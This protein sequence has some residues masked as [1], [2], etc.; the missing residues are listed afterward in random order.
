MFF[1]FFLAYLFGWIGFLPLVLT[2]VG[3]GVIRVNVPIE[4]IVVGAFT[5][6]I[7]ALCTQWMLDR[8]FRIC[9]IYSSWKRLLLGSVIGLALIM[10]AFTV[11]PGIVLVRI[12]PRALHWSALS[13][14]TVYGV[15]WSTFLGGPVNEE[16]GWR[17]F[18]LPRLQ[19]RFGPVVGSVLLGTLWAGWHLPLFFIHGWVNVP[20]WAFALILVTVSVLFTWGTNLSCFSILVPMLM[21]AAFNVSSRLLGALCQGVPTRQPELQYYLCAAGAAAVAAILLTC[22][23]L[24][25]SAAIPSVF[26]VTEDQ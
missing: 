2:N 15:N 6:T 22:G 25:R 23:R 17:G 26:S 4:F 11:L 8:S 16:P 18:A 21:H 19:A 12:S 3:M 10:I 9:H 24:G 20:V 1:S 13:A 5:P 7:A 14:P